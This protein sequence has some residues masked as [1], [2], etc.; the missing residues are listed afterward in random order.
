MSLGKVKAMKGTTIWM[1]QYV[2][3]DFSLL[4]VSSFLY[5]W[6]QGF[7]PA[8]VLCRCCSYKCAFAQ[9]QA[10]VMQIRD[11]LDH[12]EKWQ[13]KSDGFDGIPSRELSV[14]DRRLSA[15]S[16]YSLL[17][18]RCEPF[19]ELYLDPSFHRS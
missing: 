5:I 14:A 16:S 15:E 19:G 6:S 13:F 3:N 17:F 8:G 10:T 12:Q 4:C 7:L 2:V 9:C 11:A 18:R 1:S